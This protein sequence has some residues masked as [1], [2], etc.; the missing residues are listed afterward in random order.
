MK[1]QFA[2]MAYFGPAAE[3]WAPINHVEN[4]YVSYSDA[5]E[6]AQDMLIGSSYIALAPVDNDNKADV[7][8]LYAALRSAKKEFAASKKT[9]T[10][11]E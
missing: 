6:H 10:K 7:P 4:K 9:R 5:M 2:L 1:K 8:R 3:I 11:K